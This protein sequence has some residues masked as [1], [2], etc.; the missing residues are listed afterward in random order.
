AGASPRADLDRRDVLRLLNVDGSLA[1][2]SLRVVP[3]R[4]DLI[5]RTAGGGVSVRHN[6]FGRE[7]IFR[8]GPDGALYYGWTDSLAIAT[9][10]AAGTPIREFRAAVHPRPVT[11]ED[12]DRAVASLAAFKAPPLPGFAGLQAELRR[13]MQNAAPATWPAFTSFVVDDARRVWVA[14]PAADGEPVEWDGFTPAGV[15]F[16]RLQLPA[17]AVLKA[18][19]GS[20]AYAV[21]TDSL[22]VPSVVMYRITPRLP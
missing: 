14:L 2:D 7:G 12:V 8:A 22:D 19:R 18:L 1:R 5:V 9:F 3:A 13:A 20:T 17:R 21:A 10:S 4:E 11:R 6:P 16:A 15:P